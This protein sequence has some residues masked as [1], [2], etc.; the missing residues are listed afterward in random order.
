MVLEAEQRKL[1]HFHSSSNRLSMSS[2][3]ALTACSASG[4]LAVM[5]NFEPHAAES[6]SMLIRLFPL[7]TS[8]SFLTVMSLSNFVA[9]QEKAMRE[10]KKARYLSR[11]QTHFQT[12]SFSHIRSRKRLFKK[13]NIQ[14][15]HAQQ[16]LSSFAFSSSESAGGRSITLIF[17]HAPVR[18]R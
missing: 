13:N 11:L 6:T 3:S 1:Y 16:V 8:S 2:F 7:A 17:F 12:S 15:I 10:K 9:V 14:V 18:L 5:I 4:P